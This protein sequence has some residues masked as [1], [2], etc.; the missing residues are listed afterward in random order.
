LLI[1]CVASS[2]VFFSCSSV[3]HTALIHR[4]HV[5]YVDEGVFAS[6]LL[7]NLQGLLDQI[8]QVEH[9]SLLVVNFVT[10]VAILR[11]VEVQDGE[12]LPVIGHKGLAYGVGG[13]HQCLEHFE[14]NLDDLGVARI[15]RRYENGYI[16][17]IELT[18][19]RDDQLGNYW[20]NFGSALL[21]HVKGA[22][23]R[24]EAVRFVLLANPFEEDR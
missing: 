5:L 20:Q 7:E 1:C 21:E 10:D 2:D 17:L 23:D 3:E 24:Q 11:L 19:N 4:Y 16:R 6:V 12:D 15:Q 13:H 9:L 14:C 22:L 8:T 18:F